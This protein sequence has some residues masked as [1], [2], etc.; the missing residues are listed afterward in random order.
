[1]RLLES[2]TVTALAALLPS[3][4][5][6]RTAHPQATLQNGNGNAS[7]FG[8]FT[9]GGAAEARV[10]FLIPK[11]ELP[12]TPALLT[13]LELH[14]LVGGTVDYASLVITAMPTN[15]PRCF[16]QVVHLHRAPTEACR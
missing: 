14:A 9:G 7:P 1:M 10:Q 15:S 8:I 6:S 3:Q 4:Q 5:I 12:S 16:I 11:D 2:L 13:G